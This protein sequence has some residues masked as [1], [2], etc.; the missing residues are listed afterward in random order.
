MSAN[1]QLYAATVLLVVAYGIVRRLRKRRRASFPP[2]PRPYPLIGN[3]RDI[4]SEAPWKTF[5]KWSE[6]YGD[7]VYFHTLGREVVVLNSATM[8]HDLLDKRSAKYSYRPFFAMASEVIGWKWALPIMDYGEK[9]KRHRKYLQQF[10]HKQNIPKYYNIELKEVH[11]L[12][13]D[14]LDDPENFTAHIKRLAGG[15]TM[16]LTYGHEVKS[17]EDPFIRVAEKGV[18]TIEAVGAVGAHVVDFVP[19]IRHLPDWFPGAVIKRLPPGTREDLHDFLHKPFNY[20]KERLAQGTAVPCYTTTLLEETKGNDDE[21]IRGTAAITYA[22][23]FD[24][25]LSALMTAMIAL[26]AD[27]AIQMRAQEEMDSVIGKDRL[28]TFEDRARLPYMHS[29]ITETLRWGAT[30]PV[31][32]P[33]RLSQDDEYGGYCLPANCVVIA[34]TWAMLYDPRVYPEPHKFNPDRFFNKEGGIIQPDPRGPAFG[35][36]RRV[37]PGKDLAETHLW[38][39]IASMFY[40]FK[41]TPAVDES[42]KEIPIDLEFSEHSIRH[43]K[44]FKCIIK[45]RRAN[46]ASLIR[47]AKDN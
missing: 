31:G 18:L 35:F 13:N 47:H 46:S 34:N 33:H 7:M 45:P 38:I 22:G 29:I 23:G 11:H 19:W 37:C 20:V 16:M 8:A 21:G 40:A 44:P 42:G 27:P 6:Q 3:L 25:T 26:V 15:V 41:I 4:P 30:T 24:T 43:P 1:V 17:L 32:V 14:F 36:G 12:L 10:F 5:A 9:W 2:G 28:P 39:T